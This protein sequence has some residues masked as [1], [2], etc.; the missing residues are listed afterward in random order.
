MRIVLIL[1]V[2]FCLSFTGPDTLF[3]FHRSID[4]CYTDT[5]IRYWKPQEINETQQKLDDILHKLNKLNNDK[6]K[7]N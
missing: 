4:T 6:E 7:C 3:I 2:L 5:L 1:S